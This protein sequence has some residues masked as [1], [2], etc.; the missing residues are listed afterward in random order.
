MYKR[1]VLAFLMDQSARWGSTCLLGGNY[2]LHAMFGMSCN[3]HQLE[4]NFAACP[5]CVRVADRYLDAGQ[6]DESMHFACRQCY[7]FSF[8]RLV[9]R[10]K[11]GMPIH[12][13]LSVDA[14][15]YTLTDKPG[16]LSFEV[17]MD[18]W[19]YALRKLVYDNTWSIKFIVPEQGHNRL[20]YA[21]LS[22]CYSG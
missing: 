9:N 13:S 4:L 5:K 8:T 19:Q 10:G 21:L 16:T 12:E 6:F 1:L 2:K 15:G 14:P 20:L 3:F 18:A 11:Y 22:E 17:L 7:G